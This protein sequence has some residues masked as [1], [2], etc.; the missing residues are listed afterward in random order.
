[1]SSACRVSVDS[2]ERRRARAVIANSPFAIA[3]ERD[4]ARAA[5]TTSRFVA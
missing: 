2:V 1:M 4:R 5:S 3:I